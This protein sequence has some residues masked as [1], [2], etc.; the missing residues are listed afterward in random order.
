MEFMRNSHHRVAVRLRTLLV[1][2]GS[3]R[4]D[5]LTVFRRIDVDK[6]G[7]NMRRVAQLA[8]AF[9]VELSQTESETAF[10]E[11]DQNGDGSCE[12]EEFYQ[13]WMGPSLIARIVKDSVA[14]GAR[15]QLKEVFEKI[16][17]DGNGTLEKKEVA[18]AF[19]DLGAELP[20]VQLDVA[21]GEMR[22]RNE[23]SVKFQ[24]FCQWMESESLLAIKLKLAMAESPDSTFSQAAEGAASMRLGDETELW[25]AR[26]YNVKGNEMIGHLEFEDKGGCCVIA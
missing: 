24:H 12:F 22:Y 8:R 20:A 16:D 3:V 17:L 25:V 18:R 21:F 10:E 19:K 11:M 2:S 7:M 23:S 9:G 26:P 1:A 4:T 15:K 14:A 6:E 13:W 5:L